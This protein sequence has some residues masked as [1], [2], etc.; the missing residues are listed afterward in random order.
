M[1]GVDENDLGC[2]AAACRK[3][4][5]VDRG[6]G[7]DR[8]WRDG[9]RRH[10]ELGAFIDEPAQ[11]DDG[12]REVG[13]EGKGALDRA[14][15]VKGPF[16]QESCYLFPGSQREGAVSEVDAFGVGEEEGDRGGSVVGIGQGEAG[17]DGAGGLG[18]DPSLPNGGGGRDAGFRGENPVD[19]RTEYGQSGGRGHP[20][21]G[22]HLSISD[23]ELSR[24]ALGGEGNAAP[25]G[26][27]KRQQG[28][29]A[30]QRQPFAGLATICPCLPHCS[31]APAPGR[32][33]PPSSPVSVAVCPVPSCGALMKKPLGPSRY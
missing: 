12:D 8:E 29:R 17:S 33:W 10:Q 28:G 11:R 21:I 1:G 20:A 15:A 30:G 18:E 7:G 4:R 5:K 14:A 25:V 16:V 13:G 9:K 24:C 2:P 26:D 27:G 32:A 19:P 23:T 3:M 6:G 22:F 31:P